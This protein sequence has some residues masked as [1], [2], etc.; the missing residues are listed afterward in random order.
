MQVQNFCLGFH[1]FFYYRSC[2]A[3]SP[4]ENENHHKSKKQVP[5]G[6]S[7]FEFSIRCEEH[8]FYDFSNFHFQQIR[9][10]T[11]G[12]ECNQSGKKLL[13]FD[14]SYHVKHADKCARN[15]SFRK[16][17]DEVVKH[18]D[19]K[20]LTSPDPTGNRSNLGWSTGN[21]FKI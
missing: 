1:W 8:S 19:M 7:S 6:L 2:F 16:I 18:I 15:S 9:M 5:H 20:W 10:V 17:L 11:R 13:I 3:S 21:K 14:L 4:S 12:S